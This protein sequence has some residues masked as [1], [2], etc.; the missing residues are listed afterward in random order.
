MRINPLILATVAAM[1]LLGM[2]AS[3]A[4][5]VIN[6]QAVKQRTRVEAYHDCKTREAVYRYALV[7]TDHTPTGRKPN[8]RVYN[9]VFRSLTFRRAS[10]DFEYFMQWATGG[11]EHCLGRSKWKGNGNNIR[12]YGS[13]RVDCVGAFQ[14]S[15]T[16]FTVSSSTRG[17]VSPPS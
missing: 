6:R 11:W 7:C 16:V 10:C 9:C 3:S 5:A 1:L 13:A 2:T 4:G 15:I 8:I 17:G 12:R 14:S